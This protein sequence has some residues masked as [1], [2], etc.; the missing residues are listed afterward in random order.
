MINKFASLPVALILLSTTA[1]SDLVLSNTNQVSSG[2]FVEIGVSQWVAVP[3]L[4][5]GFDYELSKVSLNLAQLND[6]SIQVQIWDSQTLPG[7]GPNQSI[8][9]LTLD[10]GSST[11][12]KQVYTG[13]VSLSSATSYFLVVLEPNG[14]DL[15][16]GFWSSADTVDADM[17]VPWQF[18]LDISGDGVLDDGTQKDFESVNRGV[19]WGQTNLE[20]RGLFYMEASV[21]PEPMTLSLIAIAGGGMLVVHRIRRRED[22]V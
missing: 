15:N 4:T 16:A 19:S 18:G 20:A 10:G 13:N 22:E 12:T 11:A 7:Y 14:G 5:D 9:S 3:F 1:Y 21:V 2:G 8:G 6:N 17:N